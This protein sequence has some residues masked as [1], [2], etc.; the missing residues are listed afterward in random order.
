MSRISNLPYHQNLLY[1]ARIIFNNSIA[2]ETSIDNDCLFKKEIRIFA[3]RSQR[4]CKGF[5]QRIIIARRFDVELRTLCQRSTSE[6]NLI[7]FDGSF[8]D[9]RIPVEII[10]TVLREKKL[11]M[12]CPVGKVGD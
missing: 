6:G 7:I 4:A 5:S 2:N 10:E 9:K 3:K 12:Y 1:I 11:H 8:G